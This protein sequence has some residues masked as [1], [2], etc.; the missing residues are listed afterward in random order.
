MKNFILFIFIGILIPIVTSAQ[1]GD[2]CS[3][4]V[5]MPYSNNSI[6]T[7]NILTGGIR[8]FTFIPLT[9]EVEITLTNTDFA[10][11]H[12]H[13]L[14]LMEGLCNLKYFTIGYDNGNDTVLKII[15]HDLVVGVPYLISTIRQ[16]TTSCKS[17]KCEGLSPAAKFDLQVESLLPPIVTD[18]NGI[19]FLNG[20]ASHVK[21]EVIIRISKTYLKMNSVDNTNQNDMPV[22]VLFNLL[23]YRKW[24]ML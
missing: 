20:V 13:D 6:L 17:L 12:I 19:V 21:N 15:A 10:N 1:I 8:W 5:P 4:A 9:S 22:P 2:S 24:L 18:S 3:T 7:G 23:C 11:G 16:R 14:L